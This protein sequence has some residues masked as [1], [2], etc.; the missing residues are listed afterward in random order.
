MF[1]QSGSMDIQHA[2]NFSQEQMAY[3]GSE[4][5]LGTGSSKGR[6][7]P[8]A[9]WLTFALG[10]FILL[11]IGLAIALAV[12]GVQLAKTSKSLAPSTC[13]FFKP[14]ILF[15]PFK[16]FL[17]FFL[18]NE[19]KM[20]HPCLSPNCV[21]V[22][23]SILNKMDTTVDPCQDFYNFACGSWIRSNPV[24]PT[25]TSW[26]QFEIL[27]ENL[28]RQIKGVGFCKFMKRRHFPKKKIQ[29]L[30]NDI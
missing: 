19:L 24:P 23:G 27:R 10:L 29:S 2:Y 20:E 3:G 30:T 17:I 13:V 8:K 6:W 22:A 21:Q 5:Q 28:A 12:I 1:W 26:G 7:T 18:E 4:T 15:Q 16:I 25:E 11:T 9:Q 14:K